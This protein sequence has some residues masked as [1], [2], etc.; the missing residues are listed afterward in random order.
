M[1]MVQKNKPL[2]WFEKKTAEENEKLLQL[3]SLK[4]EQL[5]KKHRKEEK[6]ALEQ[7]LVLMNEQRAKERL[8]QDEKA[9]KIRM[10]LD[11]TK[12]H[13]GPCQNLQQIERMISFYTT[14]AALTRG[15]KAELVYNKLC[16]GYKT[17][18]VT[19]TPLAL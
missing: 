7:K 16:L 17:L 15:L 14:K 13:N 8:N 5:R 18:R 10:A 12:H 19:G 3:S 11:Q 4:G 1:A 6:A 2:Q 9:Q